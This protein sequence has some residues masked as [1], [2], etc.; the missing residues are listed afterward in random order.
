[1]EERLLGST[2]HLSVTLKDASGIRNYRDLSA[3]LAEL[4]GVTSVSPA[5][6]ET[7][8]L[9]SGSR[10]QG[11]VLKGLDPD[12]AHEW[13]SFLALLP[14]GSAEPLR[15]EAATPPL[16][17]GR[18]LA[19]RLGAFVDDPVLITSPQ[20]RLTPFGLVPKYRSFK[21]V[22]IFESG[23]YDFDAGWAYTNLAAAQQLFGLGDVV[24]ILEL[25]LRDVYAA[26]RLAPMAAQAAG[27][28]FVATPWTEHHR[29]L[30]RALKLEKLVT[31]IFIGLI[32]F[33]AGLNILVLLVMLV[34]EKRR[35]VAVL[36]SF[37]ARASQIQRIFILHGLAL[38]TL[39]TLAGLVIGYLAAGFA[40][41]RQL[42][43]L[44]PE[45]YGISF[46]PFET[47]PADG[48]LIALFALAIS[49]A[50]TLYPARRA[51]RILPVEILRYE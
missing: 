16:L 40:A 43:P 28:E 31:A 11:I 39:G 48:I 5:L 36:M 18:E 10:A 2:S 45:I 34:L 25:R 50:A 37:G 51:A 1:F 9:S 33:V 7:V 44:E 41:A 24:S 23:F 22:G 17:I 19:T 35:D 38:G 8:L 3:R 14:E 30:F 20:G 27:P 26:E 42:I 46:V 15:V 47:Q 32:V 29:S 4:P 21:V 6:Y 13:T 12:L 49:L